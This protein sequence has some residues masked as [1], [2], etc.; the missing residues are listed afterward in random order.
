MVFKKAIVQVFNGNEP[1]SFNDFVR[2]TLRLF[3][4]AVDNNIDVKIN[5]SGAE[6]E[7]YMIVT[8]F[9]YD[10]LH[11]TPKV[12]YRGIDDSLLI[13]DLDAFVASSDP[14]YIISSNVAIDRKDI[15]NLS[16]I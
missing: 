15:Y 6:F 5:I 13:K 16:Y 14:L 8:N 7:P 3:N 2:G 1:F 4:Y 12:Y 10:T 11:I 9:K